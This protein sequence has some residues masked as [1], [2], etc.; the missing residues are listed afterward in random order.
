[1][2]E[3]I[4]A[5]FFGMLLDNVLMSV[6]GFEELYQHVE[7]GFLSKINELLKKEELIKHCSCLQLALTV[8]LDADNQWSFSM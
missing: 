2:R 4:C 5:E 7:T 8:G 1:M 6:E 3:E